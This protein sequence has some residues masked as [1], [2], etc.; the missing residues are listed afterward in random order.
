MGYY[1]YH[2]LEII[3]E[4]LVADHIEGIELESGYHGVFEEQIKWYDHE[5]DMRAYS[6]KHPDIL[7]KISGEGEEAGDLWIEWHKDGKMQREKAVIS[8]GEF[9]ESKL[10]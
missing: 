2:E 9:D 5:K 3:G 4:G 10:N 8:F 6:R 1:T 7:F